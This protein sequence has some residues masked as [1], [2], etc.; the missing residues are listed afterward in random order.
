MSESLPA[1]K[2]DRFRIFILVLTLLNTIFAALLSGLQVDA[3]T[4]ADKA[5]G[6]SQYYALLASHELVR[7]G[8]QTGYDLKLFANTLNNAQQSTVLQL[9]A[10]ELEQ[11]GEE[12]S[13]ARLLS[14]AEVAQARSDKGIALSMLYSDPRYAPSEPDGI[15]DLEAYLADQSKT[16]TE[17][18]EKQNRAADEYH[19]WDN[20]ADTYIAVLSILAIAFFLLGLAQSTEHMR[21]FFGIS[22]LVVMSMAAVWTGFILIA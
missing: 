20:K 19:R 17:L 8:E 15:P 14:Q 5:N 10:L 12:E 18:V 2:P 7:M 11:A 9:T 6:E 4:R 13:A 3:G 21:L 16:P 1:P 22:A